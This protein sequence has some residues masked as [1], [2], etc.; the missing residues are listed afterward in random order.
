MCVLYVT[1]SRIGTYFRS[2]FR[3]AT[4][5]LVAST[6]QRPVTETGNKVRRHSSD[7]VSYSED[8]AGH[9]SVVYVPQGAYLFM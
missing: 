8:K 1:A 2:K 7:A 9:V 5:R 3:C 4:G 6:D